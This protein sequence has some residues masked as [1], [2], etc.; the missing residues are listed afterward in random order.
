MGIFASGPKASIKPSRIMIVPFS[1]GGPFTGT[2]LH[3]TIAYV[4]LTSAKPGWG[5]RMAIENII[6]IPYFN[7]LMFLL[8]REP[9]RI[10]IYPT[11]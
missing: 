4:G 10:Y 5:N 11:P 6:G 1:I 9:T 7:V 8:S 2:I 3:P